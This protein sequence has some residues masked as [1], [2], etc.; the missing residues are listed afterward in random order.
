MKPLH[1]AFLLSLPVSLVRAQ[2]GQPEFT[3]P[4]ALL[5]VVS[6]T[7]AAN[8]DTFHVESITETVSDNDLHRE[9]RKVYR[10][11]IKGPDNLYRIETR[12]PFGS[13]IQ[14]SDGKNEWVYLVEANMYVVRPVPQRWPQFPKIMS[15]GNEE[16]REA[17]N[18]RT[19]LETE[20]SGYARAT[21]LPGETIAIEGKRYPCYVVHVTS[22]D[23]KTARNKD[24]RWDRTFWIDESTHVFRKQ[25][26]HLDSYSIITQTIRIPFHRDTTTVYPVADFHPQ[27]PAGTFHFLPPSNAKEVASLEPDV[28]VS[29]PAPSAQMV[30]KTA[31]EI[32]FT[33]PDGKKMDLSSYRG[34]PVLIDFW[35]TWCGP[36]LLSMPAFSRIDH[37]FKSRGLIVI[38]VDQDSMPDNATEYLTRHHY[39]WTN[40]HDTDA[41]ISRAFQG[42]GIP[43]TILIDAQGKIVYYDWGGDEISLRKAIA[44]LVVKTSSSTTPP[45]PE[46]RVREP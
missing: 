17:W 28:I 5:R 36:C 27:T 12:S 1:L 30:G 42:D 15:G 20:A 24:Q 34:Q 44:S 32:S 8:P 18:M 26:E 25:I 7:Y 2:S 21:M 33:G 6:E 29:P 45:A 41:K 4:L 19:W 43:L 35:A 14:D 9:W 22:D 13:Y 3:D 23:R 31:P 16:L 40:Y 39:T 37:D 46:Q 10:T 38:S 11:A